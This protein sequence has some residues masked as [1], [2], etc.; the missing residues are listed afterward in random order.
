M[1]EVVLSAVILLVANINVLSQNVGIGTT[2]T[3]VAKLEVRSD[4]SSSLTNN[5]ILRNITG[6]TLFRVRSDG[7]VGIGYNGASY[8]RTMNIGGNGINVYKTDAVFAGAIFPT[9]TSLVIWSQIDDNNYVI[10]QPSWGNVGIGTFRPDAKLHVKGSVILGDGGTVLTR[11]I[12]VSISRNL[13]SIAANTSD[14]ETFTVT[15]ANTGS[16][17]H[18]SPAL[19]LADGLIIAY[20]RVSAADTVEVKFMNVTAASINPGTMSFFICVIE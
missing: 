6:D 8:G 1:K 13:P 7:R 14:V 10:L 15:G 3:P 17:V 18:I 12:K 4:G 16:A 19:A 2:G 9:D 11:V 20:A 5:L